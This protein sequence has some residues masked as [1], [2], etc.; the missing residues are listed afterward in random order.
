MIGLCLEKN[1]HKNHYQELE[2]FLE[3][4]QKL[5]SEMSKSQICFD[6]FVYWGEHIYLRCPL[7]RLYDFS[8]VYHL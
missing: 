6:L 5:D 4:F 7:C 3:S 1:T 8:E 2:R